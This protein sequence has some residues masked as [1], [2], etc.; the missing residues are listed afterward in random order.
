MKTTTLF[1][2]DNGN[3]KSTQN[4][5]ITDCFRIMTVLCKKQS[6]YTNDLLKKKKY[7]I[8]SQIREE[9]YPAKGIEKYN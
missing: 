4:K 2:R 1:Q 6:K 7:G 5:Q 3:I 8:E 9:K